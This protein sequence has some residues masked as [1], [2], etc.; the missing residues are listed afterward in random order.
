MDVVK[1]GVLCDARLR[2]FQVRTRFF[3]ECQER[4]GNYRLTGV[5][6]GRHFHWTQRTTACDWTVRQSRLE[7]LVRDD[8]QHVD[9]FSAK[10]FPHCGYLAVDPR[11]EERRVGK[12][13]R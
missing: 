3:I 5:E 8:F 12:E 2:R 10:F 11:S 9:V 7:S 13:C 1:G 6:L 4:V